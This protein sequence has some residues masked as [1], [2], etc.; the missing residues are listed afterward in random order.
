MMN[1]NRLQ[2]GMTYAEVVK[3]LGKVGNRESVMENGGTKIEMYKWDGDGGGA[4]AR[5]DVFF[6]NGKLD[7][8]LQ[9]ALK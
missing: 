9:F 5:L 2:T 6:K 3:I 8:K 7:S 1:F 4:D